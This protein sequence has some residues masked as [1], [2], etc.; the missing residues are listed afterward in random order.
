[1]P[2]LVGNFMAGRERKFA[3]RA[4][5]SR[6]LGEN[7]TTNTPPGQPLPSP[8]KREHGWYL[9]APL[10]QRLHEKSAL[11]TPT[12]DGGIL[13]TTEEVMF[14]HWYR[15]VP[16]PE[17]VEVWFQQEV[18]SAPDVGIRTVA[19]DLLRNGGELVVPR[20]QLGHR[21][22]HLHPATWAIRWERHEPWTKHTG[23]SQVRVQHTNDPLD[24][25]EL[26]GWVADVLG[27]GH[28]PELCVVDD[29]FDA[30]V[31]H[32][33]L[34]DPRGNQ[35]TVRHLHDAERQHVLRTCHEALP[36]DG[37]FFISQPGE[38]P[39]PAV[40]VDHFSGRFL[41]HEERT[42]LIEPV[43]EGSGAVY[44][45]LS[46]RGLLLRPGFKYG[47]KWRVYEDA[48]HAEHAPWLVQTRSGAPTT[49]EEV[50]LAVRLAEGV[51]KKWLCAVDHS[52]E[53]AYL[54]IQRSG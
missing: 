42:H 36:M 34:A 54:N 48:V 12:S 25:D 37:G 4:R 28:V 21:F 8:E 45:N 39:L 50:C 38:W 3:P 33:V 35:R 31:Y 24:W 9:P 7:L 2:C 26:H 47:C 11:G 52:G 43:S 1:M 5:T 14:A 10:S 18:L 44:A 16:L 19:M 46:E 23:F 32:L 53:L 41:R 17:P 29:E 27:G 40:G 30:T 22:P 49:W 51:N 20:A 6:P 15:H 13:L